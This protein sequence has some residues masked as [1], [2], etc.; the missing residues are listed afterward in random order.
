MAYVYILYSAKLDRYYIGSTVLQPEE[1]LH[2]HNT[3][4]YT[5]KF[6]EKGIPWELFF[7][8]F[9]NSRSQAEAIEKH[10]KRMKSRVFIENLKRYPAL[11]AKLKARYP[12]S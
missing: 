1:R 8:I 9:C 4:Y 5:D 10:V 2:R 11:V 3:G 6:T 7:T 12:D